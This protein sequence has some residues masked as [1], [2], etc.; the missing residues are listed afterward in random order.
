MSADR[1]NFDLSDD[2]DDEQHE[3]VHSPPFKCDFKLLDFSPYSIRKPLGNVVE[4]TGPSE[5]TV[6]AGPSKVPNA[7]ASTSETEDSV[8]SIVDEESELG[9]S[10]L[11]RA[12]RA[13]KQATGIISS[14]SSTQPGD[15]GGPTEDV[16]MADD[17]EVTVR[18]APTVLPKRRIW[19]EDV[20]TQLLYQEI[21][22]KVGVRANG[23]M[24]DDQRIIVV[25]VSPGVSSWNVY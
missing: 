22:R 19:K 25:C 20:T 3:L 13:M 1:T 11:N 15:I 7:G 2:D 18:H 6:Y 10:Y 21:V 24:M 12:L 4:D 8:T 16:G 14:S 5:K 17:C 9:E 23:V